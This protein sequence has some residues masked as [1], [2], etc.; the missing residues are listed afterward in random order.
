[1]VGGRPPEIPRP[2]AGAERPDA[3]ADA[4]VEKAGSIY[5]SVGRYG[6]KLEPR[7]G[8]MEILIVDHI[9]KTPTEN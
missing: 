6:L 7:K 3:A 2:A 9:E 8:P 5:E 1:M 4:T